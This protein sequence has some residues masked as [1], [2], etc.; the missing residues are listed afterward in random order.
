MGEGDP[1]RRAEGKPRVGMASPEHSNA[2]ENTYTAP[3]STEGSGAHL[4]CLYTNAR[5]MRNEQDELEA[6]ISS[7]SYDVIGI[8]ETSWNDW[9][10]TGCSGGI[11][12]AGEVEELHCM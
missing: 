4:K 8:S 10:A 1:N 6:L 5:S 12:R 9:R 11:G 7:Q 2:S 3:G